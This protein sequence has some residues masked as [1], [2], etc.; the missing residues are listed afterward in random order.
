MLSDK[1]ILCPFDKNPCIQDSC[2]VWSRDKQ[3]CSFA[4]L[5][6]LL[7]KQDLPKIPVR[8]HSVKREN[9]GGSGKYRTLLFD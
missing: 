9:E 1:P 6:F 2:A 8:E 5:P 3:L 7:T 4:L